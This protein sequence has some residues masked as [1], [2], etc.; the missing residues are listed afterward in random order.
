MEERFCR[1]SESEIEHLV[2]WINH[3]KP[4]RGSGGMLPWKF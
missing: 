3:R 1:V 2:W 4:S